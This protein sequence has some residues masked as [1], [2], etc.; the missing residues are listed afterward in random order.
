M[1]YRVHVSKLQTSKNGRC[2]VTVISCAREIEFLLRC[3][4]HQNET[5]GSFKRDYSSFCT[6]FVYENVIIKLNIF[7][8]VGGILEIRCMKVCISTF[9]VSL[10]VIASII[11]SIERISTIESR[12]WVNFVYSKKILFGEIKP[13]VYLRL[14]IAQACT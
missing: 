12:Q 10:T 3:W 11:R 2:M 9:S 5:S 7:H 14:L 4:C 6:T 1:D 13:K 8:G